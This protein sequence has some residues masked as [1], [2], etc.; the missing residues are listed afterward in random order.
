MDMLDDADD[1]QPI[2]FRR[3]STAPCHRCR[4]RVQRRDCDLP[5]WTHRQLSNIGWTDLRDRR[6]MRLRMHS[7]HLSTV[8]LLLRQ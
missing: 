2:H 3:R 4:Q 8:H 7:H 6:I 1:I 5:K